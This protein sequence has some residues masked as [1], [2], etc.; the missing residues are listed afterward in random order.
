MRKLVLLFSLILFSNLCIGQ[1][2]IFKETFGATDNLNALRVQSAFTAY[3]NPSLFNID[4][5]EV[6]IKLGNNSSKDYDE[7]SGGNFVHMKGHWQWDGT[8]NLSDTLVITSIDTRGYS[9]IHLSFGIFNNTGWTG[10]TNHAFEGYYSTNGIDWTQIDKMNTINGTSFP[11]AKAWGWVTL[12]ES[13]PAVENLHMMIVNPASNTHDCF[14]DD[15]MLT[16]YLPDDEPPSTPENLVAGTPDFNSVFLT[17]N[18]AID[19]YNGITYQV[20]KNGAYLLTTSDTV[21]HV[22]YQTPGS[23]VDFSVVAV[24]MSGNVS[25]ESNS[26]SVTFQTQ[27]VDFEYSW[28]KAHANVLPTGN[29]EWQPKAFQFTHGSSVRYIDF[30]G[31]DDS[32]DGLSTS[33]AWK[34]HPWDNNASENAA[35]CSGGHTYV[36]KRG[37]VYRGKLVAKESGHFNEP[38][39]LT[40]DPSW[41][42]GEAYIFGSTRFTDGW[43]QAD[44]VSAPNIPDP[45]KVW[46]RDVSLPETKYIC[47]IDGENYKQ[48]IVARTPNYEENPDYPVENW[49]KW[50]NKQIIDDK[51]IWLTDTKNLTQ[52]NPEYFQGASVYSSDDAWVMST[53]RFLDVVEWDPENNRVKMGHNKFGGKNCHYFIENTPFLLDTTGEFYYDKNAQ[54]LFIRLQDDKNPNNA[55]IEVSEEEQLIEIDNQSNI[56]ISGLTFG[57]TTSKRDRMGEDGAKTAIRMTGL[58][59]RIQIKNNKFVCLNGGVSLHSNGATGIN[60]H[61]ITVCDNEFQNIGD[62]SITFS[63]SGYFLD[64]INILRNKITNVGYRQLGR[65]WSPIAAVYANL[66]YGEISGNIIDVSWGAGIDIFWGKNKDDDFSVPFV[67]GFIHHNQASRTLLGTNDWGGIESWQG[68]PTYFYN[69]RSHDAVGIRPVDNQSVGYAFYLDGAFKQY[70][71][72]NIAS[73]LSHERNAAG[74]QQ[75]LG[76]YNMYIHNTC[77]KTRS[78]FDSAPVRGT[79]G[80]NTYLSNISDDVE[81]FFWHKVNPDYIPF[82]SY[83]NNISSQSNFI[84]SLEDKEAVLSLTD[85]KTKLEGYHSQLTQ[86]GWSAVKPV[87]AE[88]QNHDFRPFATGEGIDRG[89]RFFSSF[90]LAK[91]VGEWN[92]YKHP[93]DLNIIMGDNLYLT[94]DFHHR[95]MYHEVAKNHLTAHNVTEENFVTGQLENWTEGALEFDGSSVYC[96]ISHSD[97]NTVKSNNIDMTD[98]DFIIELFLKTSTGHNN[99]TL[100]SKYD[101]G[102]GYELGI[103]ANGMAQITLFDGGTAVTSRISSLA[104]NDGEWHHV[105]VEINRHAGM[106]VYVDGQLKNG[107]LSGSMPE[108]SIS[109]SNTA[110]LLV[111]KNTEGNYFNGT[112][113]FLRISKGNLYEAKTTVAE[114]YEWETN[115]PFLYDMTG[116]APIGKRDAGA[117]EI[118]EKSCEISVAPEQLEFDETSSTQNL[119]VT[120][121]EGFELIPNTGNLFTTNVSGNTIEVTV[122]ENTRLLARNDTLEVFGCNETV[123]VPVVQSAAPCTIELKS[124]NTTVSEEEQRVKIPVNTNGTLN[125]SCSASFAAESLSASG[126]TVYIDLEANTTANQRVAEVEIDACNETLTFTITQEGT[127]GLNVFIP[128]GFDIYPNPVT[129]GKLNI[130]VPDYINQYRYTITD[131]TGKLLKTNNV[132][133]TANE[134]NLNLPKGVYVLTINHSEINFSIA[135]N[136]L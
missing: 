81:I 114:L 21:A 119:T 97:V 98:N 91:V 132:N 27:P 30:E 99:S 18:A 38:I 35:V 3:D 104:I 115:G 131:I 8:T 13:L 116:K 103:D 107:A 42:S 51:Y 1:I 78:M 121:S 112:M 26:V 94:E 4:T 125:I 83:G 96:S 134:I 135:I 20:F 5:V 11:G 29:L 110:D 43:T 46:Y 34:H 58:C 136:V 73:G 2:Q 72:N 65:Q 53:V 88:P 79:N 95:N 113:D 9:D 102:S 62:L 127:T 87:I 15:I 19:N 63:S 69:N 10:I 74:F 92:F 31:G 57:M 90:P 23:T 71:F 64:N 118:G 133:K 129:N 105:L 128:E 108:T 7:A 59:S 77:Y 56:E 37:V 75:V 68:G 39:R 50:T 40:S 17:W 101:G 28:Q 61:D 55:I 54:R 52:T 60:S 41:G 14:I 67:R 12:G 25:S 93:A 124:N 109:L 24:D 106:D 86:A 48:L 32:N 76:F 22:K 84:S 80:H 6:V 45:E 36:F 100:V 85:F 123:Q 82:E 89:V 70:V 130:V 122:S 111:G 47:E 126:D 49:W 117:L 33:T 44:A 66:N 16:G 120:A